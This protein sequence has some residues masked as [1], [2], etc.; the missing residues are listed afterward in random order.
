LALTNDNRLNLAYYSDTGI[1]FSQR[2][3]NGTWSTPREIHKRTG[4]A[5]L[6]LSLGN[7]Q[8]LHLIWT[9][10]AYGSRRIYYTQRKND[11]TWLTVHALTDSMDLGN[12][13]L[14]VD[15][16]NLAHIVWHV[17]SQYPPSLYYMR[18]E[19]AGLWSTPE[20]LGLVGQ[21]K[22]SSLV[23]SDEGTLH[24]FWGGNADWGEDVYHRQQRNGIWSAPTKAAAAEYLFD[25][26]QMIARNDAKIRLVWQGYDFGP[27]ELWYIETAPV[28]STGTSTLAT[29]VTLPQ[30][31]SVPVLSFLYQLEGVSSDNHSWFNVDVSNGMS[32]TT[33]LSTTSS[34][35]GQWLHS[36]ASLEAWSGQAVTL[37]FTLHQ[38]A[39]NEAG[40]VYLDEVSVGTTYPDLWV[41]QE[42]S[43]ALPG[44]Q[45]IYTLVYGNQGAA[46][47]ENVRIV[48]LL[49]TE[50]SYVDANPK[51]IDETAL[52]P[53]L[54]WDLGTLPAISKPFTVVITTTAPLTVPMFSTLT[55]TTSIT[56]ASP[57]LELGNNYAYTAIFVGYRV[58]L[59]LTMRNW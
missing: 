49:P 53:A 7:D 48:D 12:P 46:P 26:P 34:V 29:V 1:Y 15:R 50:L 52:L 51:P 30:S 57:E 10:G 9:A 13:Q 44:S 39:N 56:S 45:V 14:V 58:Y 5:N 32:S 47:A 11:G 36:W 54:A 42:S 31:P 17:S 25:N 37:T 41:T 27:G 28:T 16:N 33:L 22:A 38:T 2:Y 4:V 59:P 43:E 19:Y 21:S 6:R 35:A 18:Q 3:A 23:A 40:R 20:Y 24:L 8:T 55:N